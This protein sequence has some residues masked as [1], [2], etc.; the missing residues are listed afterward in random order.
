MAA[1]SGG[2]GHRP[3]AADD[4]AITQNQLIPGLGVAILV[5]LD[6]FVMGDVPAERIDKKQ[7][8]QV[9]KVIN[10]VPWT[11]RFDKLK[12]MFSMVNSLFR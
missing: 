1:P 4:F 9:Q 7:I 6:F 12:V 3:R 8:P 5:H 2:R 10:A 11:C